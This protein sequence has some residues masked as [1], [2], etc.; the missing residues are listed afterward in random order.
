MTLDD[1]LKSMNER[2][3][4]E[5]IALFFEGVYDTYKVMYRMIG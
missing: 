3:P 4:L 1:R 5:K 2:W